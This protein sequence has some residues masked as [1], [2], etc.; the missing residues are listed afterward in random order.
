MRIL[1]LYLPSRATARTLRY[2]VAGW[3]AAALGILLL[4]ASSVSAQEADSVV[5]GPGS[6]ILS[7]SEAPVV[8]A[9]RTSSGIRLDGMP[10]EAAWAAATPM[11]TFTQ[12]DPYE[13]EPVSQLTEVRFLYDDD[14][15]YV[16]GR[17]YDS[18]PVWTRLARGDTGVPDSDFVVVYIDSYHDHQTSYRLATNPSGMKR[19][20]IVTS[21]GGGGPGGGGGLGGGGGGRGFG[22]TSWDPVWDV[23]ST[24]TD[25]G[26]FTEMR[27]PSFSQLRFSPDD[28]MVWGIQVERTIRRLAETAAFSFTPKLFRCLDSYSKCNNTTERWP[29]E[30]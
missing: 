22:D 24:I 28:E 10:D 11:T 12:I 26:W 25:E 29:Q 19:D 1:R 9:V 3:S 5:F 8:R 16:G 14:A 27:I 20:E 30:S 2:T 15:L 21:G 18:G 13:G 7:H 17:L 4:W 23:A 6:E